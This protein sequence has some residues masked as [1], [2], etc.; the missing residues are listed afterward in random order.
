MNLV[1]GKAY[2]AVQAA[3]SIPVS[4]HESVEFDE[5]RIAFEVLNKPC[6]VMVDNGVEQ[7][8]IDLPEHL[9]AQ[10]WY[11]VQ[12]LN[13]HKSHWFNTGGYQISDFEKS[14]AN[15]KE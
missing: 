15:L 5:K 2:L 12:N 11:W 1:V 9:K 8:F 10:D 3:D 6:K 13:S 14:V 4:E 7:S